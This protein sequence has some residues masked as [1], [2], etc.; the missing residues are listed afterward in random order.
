MRERESRGERR[1]SAGIAI[2][3]ILALLIAPF[4]A[5]LCAAKSCAWSSASSGSGA[6]GCH[7]EA[8]ADDRAAAQSLDTQQISIA[9]ATANTC[10]PPEAQPATPSAAKSWSGLSQANKFAPYF[11][12]SAF[13][14]AQT[15]LQRA[16]RAL[17]LQSS[18]TFG[19]SATPSV[20]TVLR[21]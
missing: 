11:L 3:A 18:T 15:F 7:H 1:K 2:V 19:R 10:N 16:G 17:W 9:A 14:Q 21:I 20:T 12:S 13:G 8:P 5:P 4:C 6:T